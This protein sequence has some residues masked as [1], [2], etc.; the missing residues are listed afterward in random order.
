VK[1]SENQEKHLADK[2]MD[3]ANI[4]LA[5]L[6]IGGSTGQVIPFQIKIMGLFLFFG[7]LSFTMHLKRNK[8]I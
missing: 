6:V 8:K 3:T 7:I 4:I 1:L 2:G 5:S